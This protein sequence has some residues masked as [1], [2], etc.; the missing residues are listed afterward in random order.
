MN[1]IWFY[2]VLQLVQ[3]PTWLVRT[4]ELVYLPGDLPSSSIYL[5]CFII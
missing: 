3:A 5:I 1:G 2:V 4:L